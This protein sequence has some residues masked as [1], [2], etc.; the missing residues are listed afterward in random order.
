MKVPYIVSMYFPV[1]GLPLDLPNG[2]DK[3]NIHLDRQ[4]Q[5]SFFDKLI[6]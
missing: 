2:S 1:N 6:L 5:S 4:S 3:Q